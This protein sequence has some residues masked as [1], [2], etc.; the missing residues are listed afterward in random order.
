MSRP[1]EL[2]YFAD[3]EVD[4][5]RVSPASLHLA[6]TARRNR[7][8]SPEWYAAHFDAGASVRGEA[9]PSYSAPWLDVP[10]RMAALIPGARLIFCIREPVE[11]AISHYVLNTV[12]RGERRPVDEALADRRSPYILQSRYRSCLEPFLEHYPA[13]QLLIVESQDLLRRRRAA[14]SAV[15]RFAGIDDS[16]WSPKA[17]RELNPG[18]EATALRKGILIARKHR[19]LR[20]IRRLPEGLR[21]RAERATTRR[22]HDGRPDLDPV[23]RAELE[24][25]L[26]PEYE[27]LRAAAGGTLAGVPL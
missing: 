4:R 7:G 22:L 3:G 12:A 17:E 15:Y 5:T 20:W 11:R 8:R 23:L 16:F 6:L 21:W 14:L 19:A 24:A 27:P 18:T 2:H 10:G 26:R 25:E 9:S 1:K 13:E